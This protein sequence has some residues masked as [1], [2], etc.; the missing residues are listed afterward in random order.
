MAITRCTC[1]T[2]HAG[3]KTTKELPTEL[4]CPRCRSR[5]RFPP[6]SRVRLLWLVILGL[7]AVLF[8]TTG[9]SLAVYCFTTG[10]QRPQVAPPVA[11]TP[12]PPPSVEPNRLAHPPESPAVH[13]GG[14]TEPPRVQSL[15]PE[16][17]RVNQAIDRGV[18]YLKA[19]LN[20]GSEDRDSYHSR[21]GALALTGLTLLSC[22]VPAN[23]PSVVRVAQRV[24]S[25][26]GEHLGQT[27]DI[28]LEILFLDRLGDP[29]D[30]E[31]IQSLALRLIAGQNQGGGWSYT[32]PVLS[33]EEDQDLQVL[34]QPN[35]GADV[36]K[37]PPEISL[38]PALG[39]RPDGKTLGLRPRSGK[40][41][42]RKP[43]ELPVV[44][45]QPGEKLT[46]TWIG[47]NSNTQFALLGV[48]TARK[49]GV[50]VER[51]LAMVE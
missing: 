22:G 13:S 4:D 3:L 5:F 19:S 17:I 25:Q 32:C 51:S 26:E 10:N 33:P 38:L 14:P 8:L 30:R 44:R 28:S 35:L 15:T 40:N 2:C 39:K 6:R 43:E 48:W 27:Y 46:D 29:Q 37:M 7:A 11:D 16:Q 50:P 1:P 24:R 49:Y 45:F 41:L 12:V 31:L 36:G 34:L 42:R 18:A 47:D 21:L 23:D 20:G 9:I